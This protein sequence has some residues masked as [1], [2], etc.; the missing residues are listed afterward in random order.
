MLGLG[1]RTEKSGYTYTPAL[2]KA[3]CVGSGLVS[4][5]KDLFQGFFKKCFPRAFRHRDYKLLAKKAESGWR[6]ACRRPTLEK[7]P[8][9]AMSAKL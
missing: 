8:G 6:P 2:A 9:S 7:P 3:L 4:L 1:D 5:Q